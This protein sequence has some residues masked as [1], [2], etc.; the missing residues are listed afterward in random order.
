MAFSALEV[1]RFC[2]L[3]SLHISTFSLI[4]KGFNVVHKILGYSISQPFQ[5]NQVHLQD[6][7]WPDLGGKLFSASILCTI[8][9]VTPCLCYVVLCCRCPGSDEG[10]GTYSQWAGGSTPRTRGTVST[11]GTVGEQR[12]QWENRGYSGRT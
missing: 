3:Y 4:L 1:S 2:R 10:T 7:F 12:V 5:R 6:L 8:V 9:A 11:M